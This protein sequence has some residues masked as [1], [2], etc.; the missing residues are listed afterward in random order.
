MKHPFQISIPFNE[1]M[2]RYDL[3]LAIGDF[4]DKEEAEKVSKLLI[5]YLEA[6]VQ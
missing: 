3:V 5:A 6:T 4:E 2:Q 1:K